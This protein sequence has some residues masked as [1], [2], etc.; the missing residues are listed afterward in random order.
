MKNLFQQTKFGHCTVYALANL[1]RSDYFIKN[2]LTDEYVGCDGEKV[3]HM[4]GLFD[5]NFGIS[6]V[7]SIRHSYE[8]ALPNDLVFQVLTNKDE[9]SS[10][11]AEEFDTIPY[12]LTIRRT[13]ATNYWHS[14]IVLNYK[15]RLFYLDP[16]YDE[17]V[18]IES[19]EQLGHQY[20]DC[21]AVERIYLKNENSF[22]IF[23]AKALGFELK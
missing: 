1:F 17:F 20:G 3:N 10:D 7:L 12:L 19:A 14:V 13:G 23:S 8:I 11:L 9:A 5:P 4:L 15:G 16:Y 22:A 6:D 18:P 2:F 21:W